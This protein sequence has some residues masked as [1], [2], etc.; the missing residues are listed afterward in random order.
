MANAEGGPAVDPEPDPEL[1][2]ALADLLAQTEKEPVSP[3]L[4]ELARRLETA[5]EDARHRRAGPGKAA[6]NGPGDGGG[7]GKG[8][9]AR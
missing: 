6:G 8:G 3:R 4:R 5:L 1:D 9:G 2:R 7:P